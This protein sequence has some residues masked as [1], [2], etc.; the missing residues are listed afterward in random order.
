MNPI[1]QGCEKL[2][3]DEKYRVRQGDYRVVYSVDD[4]HAVLL[5]K[6]GQRKE[7]YR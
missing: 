7:V 4:D 3:A 2:S 6:A 5:V 1:P